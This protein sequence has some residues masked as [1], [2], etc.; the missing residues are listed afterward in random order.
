VPSPER[1]SLSQ[2]CA[3]SS[4]WKVDLGVMERVWDSADQ[5]EQETGQVVTII[6]GARSR[7]QQLEL[8]RRGRPTA[9]PSRSTHLSCPA[10]GVDVRIGFAPTNAVKV[11]WGRIVTFQGLRWGGG[12]RVDPATGIPSDWNHVDKGPRFG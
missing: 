10:T 5:M 6:S 3:L 12:S 9:D 7:A 8:K 2:P 1:I 11:T 4:R